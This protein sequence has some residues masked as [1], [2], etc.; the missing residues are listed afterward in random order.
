M[1]S[2][3]NKTIFTFIII[4]MCPFGRPSWTN[5][6]FEKATK[7]IVE[8]E[9]QFDVNSLRFKDLKVWPLIR[10]AI[11]PQL[12]F[13]ELKIME[14]PEGLVSGRLPLI[15]LKIEKA[16]KILSSYQYLKSYVNKLCF[17]K[18]H[19]EKIVGKLDIDI[20][21]FSRAQEHREQ[22]GGAFVNPFLDPLIHLT[23]EQ[24]S[25]MKIEVDSDLVRKNLPRLEPTV[26]INAIR[27]FI[28]SRLITGT[29][30]SS[31]IDKI[32]N[33]SEFKTCVTNI[34][35]GINL[36]ENYY[37]RIVALF[38]K[39]ERFFYEVLTV[40]QPKVVFLVCYYDPVEMGLISAC[41]RLSIK[42]V[43]VQHG[44]QGKYHG[45][46]THWT[47][48]FEEG[49][50]LLPDFFWVWGE[51]TKLNIQ[52]FQP[53][54]LRKNIPVVGGNLWLSQWMHTNRYEEVSDKYV[55]FVKMLGK[56]KKVILYT[57]HNI[58]EPFLGCLLEAMRMSP[59]SWIWLIRLHPR[60]RNQLAEIDNFL[61]TKGLDNYEMR[62]STEISLYLL[63]KKVDYHLT[64]WSS[65]CYEALYFGVPTT[66]VHPNGATLYEEYIEKG[67][68]TY[69][70]DVRELLSVIESDSKKKPPTEDAPYIETDPE[71][72]REALEFILAA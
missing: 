60:L 70:A 33:F 6:D 16:R 11:Y 35:N 43:D 72:A 51:K 14:L 66:I 69:A 52:R 61:Q 47:R 40:I 32:S 26:F 68:F 28:R 37:I 12:C 20:L 9:R 71:K 55:D 15:K 10:L 62:I 45:M 4:E 34:C 23:S 18:G 58:A 1:A 57:S 8:I 27:Y 65:V 42:T 50:E 19:L 24:H 67:I 59:D 2:R 25:Q 7:T 48:A 44:G 63:L 38:K 31:Q 54:G 3:A 30:K 64:C 49:Y 36:D 56:Y 39:F 17:H 13:P 41:R 53:D 21:F 29:G 5:M 46:Y 22:V